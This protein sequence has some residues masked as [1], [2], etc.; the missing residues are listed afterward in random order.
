MEELVDIIDENDNIIATLSR[1]EMR[2]KNLRHR[3]T[4]I[5][6][7]NSSGEIFITKRAESKETFPGLY[8]IG[9]GGVVTHGET[10]EDSAKREIK[11]EV[12]V[13]SAK[14]EFLFDFHYEDSKTKY[15]ARTFAL[16][17]RSLTAHSERRS[18]RRH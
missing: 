1:K 12:G 14:L 15:I 16:A 3:S 4:F 8:E 11:E 6:V 2:E 13:N 9:Q 7:F 10:Y 5:L 18:I 17:R